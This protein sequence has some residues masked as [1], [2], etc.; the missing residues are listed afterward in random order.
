MSTHTVD[1]VDIYSGHSEQISY[2]KNLHIYTYIYISVHIHMHM[3]IY[4]GRSGQI[5]YAKS[6][7][8]HTYICEHRTC[9]AVL[10]Y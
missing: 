4:S 9:V 8:V 7:Y 1:V 6:L 5:S 3:H 2:A 10:A